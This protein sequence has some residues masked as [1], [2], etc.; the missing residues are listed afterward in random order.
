M[1]LIHLLPELRYDVDG[2][3]VTLTNYF[4][5]YK[6]APKNRSAK[7]FLKNYLTKGTTTTDLKQSF[8]NNLFTAITQ[9][10]ASYGLSP[11]NKKTLIPES[12]K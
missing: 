11:Y 6:V 9:S 7:E 2:G 4:S 8:P 5:D 3:K 10:P 12:L 1:I